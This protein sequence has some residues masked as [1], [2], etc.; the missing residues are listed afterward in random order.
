MI[1]DPQRRG[2]VRMAQRRP[3]PHRV[4]RRT[5]PVRGG[6]RRLRRLPWT[7]I[8]TGIGAVA[9]IGGLIFTGV[10]TYYAAVVSRQQLDQVKEDRE[11][12]SREQA[13][14]ITLWADPYGKE[15][16]GLHIANRSPDAATGARVVVAGKRPPKPPSHEL[17]VYVIQGLTLP[18]CSELAL[19]A[20]DIKTAQREGHQYSLADEG[21]FVDSLL[22]TD[23]SGQQWRRTR[24]QLEKMTPAVTVSAGGPGGTVDK[25][26][27]KF[28]VTALDGDCAY[29]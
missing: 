6:L 24:D 18:P 11:Q 4:R 27:P 25:V 9:A 29:K 7:T 16:G 17:A 28:K 8:G 19:K 13:S 22:F 3:S 12:E 1:N 21:M 5:G 15:G 14:R 23:A 2:R 20:T 10:A 26:L